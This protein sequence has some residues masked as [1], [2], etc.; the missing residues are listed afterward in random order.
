MNG[1][2]PYTTTATEIQRH[3]KRVI[4]RVKKLKE[5]VAVLSKNKPSVVLMDYNKF[6]QMQA[7]KK[8]KKPLFGIWK[9]L[10]IRSTEIDKVVKEW[11]SKIDQL[12]ARA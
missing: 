2:M 1:I 12:T 7:S 5:P 4:K 9:H 11:D 6:N 3:F 8:A 10:N